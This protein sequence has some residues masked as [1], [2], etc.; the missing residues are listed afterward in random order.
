MPNADLFVG[1]KND[2]EEEQRNDNFRAMCFRSNI[3]ET[4]RDIRVPFSL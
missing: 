2:R 1:K 3:S 4:V